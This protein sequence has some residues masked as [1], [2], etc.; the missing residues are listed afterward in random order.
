MHQHHTFFDVITHSIEESILLLPY[1]FIAYLILE[2]LEK[3]TQK[4]SLFFSKSYSVFTPV[5]AA[6]SGILPQCGLSVAGANFYATRLIS[7]GTIVALFLATSDEMLPILIS[8]QVPL[9]TIATIIFYKTL[10]AI[11]AGVLLDRILKKKNNGVQPAFQMHSLCQKV[12][13]GCA[14]SNIY[15]SA[16]KHTLNI[17]FF[18]LV[19]NFVLNIIF[20]FIHPNELK[21]SIFQHPFFSPFFGALFG[22]IPNCAT[23]VISAQLYA[24][25]NLPNGTFLSAVLSNAGIG[26]VVLFHVNHRLKQNIK[27]ILYLFLT[28]FISGLI[29][30]FFNISF[31][32]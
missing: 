19:I 7:T 11:F 22:L 3:H 30:N 17:F 16:L 14:H 26:L 6:L 28:A 21:E 31:D 10:I 23:S 27:I 2:Y 25:G 8:N 9:Q 20:L 4:V 18:I 13:C 32:F 12:E 29:F 15:S 5:F 1:L 24:D